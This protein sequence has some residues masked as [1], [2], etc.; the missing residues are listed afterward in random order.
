[1][2]EDLGNININIRDAS[3]SGGGGAGGGSSGGGAGGGGSSGGGPRIVVPPPP[4]LV[5]GQ[6][7]TMMQSIFGKLNLGKLISTEMKDLITNPS[8]A[9][10]GELLTGTSAAGEALAGLGAIALPATIA[11]AAVVAYAAFLYAAFK[12]LQAAS[13]AVAKRIQEVN[14]YSGT[15]LKAVALEQWAAIGRTLREASANGKNYAIVQ[16]E[17]TRVANASLEISIAWNKAMSVYAL[18]FNKF[19]LLLNRAF[20]PLARLIGKLYDGIFKVVA[21]PSSA[22][23][24]AKAWLTLALAPFYGLINMVTFVGGIFGLLE[25]VLIYLGVISKNTAP[26][27]GSDVNDWFLADVYAMRG[28]KFDPSKTRKY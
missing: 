2:A 24:W 18:I 7:K 21:N 25:K 13:E 1:M 5:G 8:I 28:M 17:M 3:G 10:F 22:P 23:V 27:I 16:A 12:L 14:K 20:A 19:M 26:A 6:Q 9:G 15:L 4:P 11:L